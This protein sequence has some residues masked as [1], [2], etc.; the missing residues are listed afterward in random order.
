MEAIRKAIPHIKLSVV[1]FAT[2]PFA[3]QLKIVRGTDLLVGVHGAGLTHLMFLQPGS[4]VLELLP[5]GLQHKG[6]R[7][8]SQ[9][10]GIVYF[11]T[12]IKMHGDASGD[13][14][15]QF[16]AVE[17]DQHQLLDLINYGHWL[18]GQST[19]ADDMNICEL[20]FGSSSN[21]QNGPQMTDSTAVAAAENKD[22][23]SAVFAPTRDEIVV[24]D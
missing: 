20:Q 14:Q 24:D 15:W 23:A 2:I 6:F 1:D 4:A 13:D 16:D 5:E 22:K 11:R 9:M 10:L 18:G 17:V 7:N 12:H 8:L 21:L 3:E 19:A